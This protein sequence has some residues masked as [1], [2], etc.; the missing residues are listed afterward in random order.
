MAAR[1]GQ[2]SNLTLIVCNRLLFEQVRRLSTSG[3]LSAASWTIRSKS[4]RE[5]ILYEA[6]K[7]IPVD[8]VIKKSEVQDIFIPQKIRR[9]PTAILEALASTVRN[10]IN[11]PIYST[12]DDPFLY[13]TTDRVKK[14]HLAA[15]ESGRKAAQ[16]M[17]ALYPDYFTQIWEEPLPDGWKEGTGNLYTEPCEAALI[18]RIAKRKVTEAVDMY[19]TIVSKGETLSQESQ[20]KLL[21]LLVVFNCKDPEEESD[22]GSYINAPDYRTFSPFPPNTWKKGNAAEEVFDALPEQS[23]SA[24]CQMI[25]GMAAN[26]HKEGV[27]SMFNAMKANKMPVDVETYNAILKVASLDTE[28]MDDVKLFIETILKDMAENKVNPNERTFISAMIN[29][30]RLSRWSGSKKFVLA[31][32][33]EM[34]ACGIEPGL[35]TYVE[36]LHIFYYFKDKTSKTP[37]LFEQVLKDLEGKE[38]ECKTENDVQFFRSVMG[39]IAAHFPDSKLALRVHELL[40][41]GKNK[42]LL[43]NRQAQYGYYSDL[44]SVII[45]LEH[46]DVVMDLYREV[47]P[48][49]FFPTSETYKLILESIEMHENYHYVPE[50]YA[51]LQWTSMFKDFDFL[52]RFTQTL[53]KRKHEAKLQNEIC[54]IAS[55]LM[56]QWATKQQLHDALPV[57]GVVIG[58]LIITHLNNDDLKTAWSLF[59]TYRNNR[60]MRGAD[61]SEDSL[62]QL[63]KHVISSQ[64]FEDTKEILHVMSI[65]DY[66]ISSLV[67]KSLQNMSLSDMERNYIQGLS[68]GSISSSSSSDSSDSD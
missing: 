57:N 23:A 46:V 6:P 56:D 24:Y 18:E 2:S 58:N 64:D 40:Q 55:S 12:I 21:E 52:S 27:M 22:I 1:V 19:R 4:K 49:I 43:S 35:S 16:H 68:T 36:I 47:V 48:Y 3:L 61:P 33:S 54:M 51:D 20:E 8:K 13:S 17:L 31:L 25:R 60:R 10:D 62:T 38:F 65:L 66:N 9:S 63:A 53:A 11:Q 26:Y 44:F 7:S 29:C 45:P 5:K 15:F 32:L 28:T 39:M 50:V 41:H 14:S 67:E 42:D 59:Q 37:E 34:K 30:R